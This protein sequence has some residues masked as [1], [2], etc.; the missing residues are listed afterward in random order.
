VDQWRFADLP[1]AMSWLKGIVVE[2][3][4]DQEGFRAVRPTF[5]LVGY[6][7]PTSHNDMPVSLADHHV[8]GKADFMPT[9]RNAFV[10]H[11]FALDTPPILR[12][13]MA[14]GDESRD[15]TSRQA[16]LSLKS[17]GAYSVRG[18]ESGEA[19]A[20]LSWQFDYFADD[21]R[22]KEGKPVPGEKT[23]TPLCFS[24]SPGMLH[25]AHAKKVHIVHVVRKSVVAK[26]AAEKLAPPLPPAPRARKASRSAV[27]G[28]TDEN[29]PPPPPP[30]PPK[31]GASHRRSRS[32]AQPMAPL[33]LA[34]GPL[35]PSISYH[36]G[37]ERAPMRELG[38]PRNA[39]RHIVPKD[40]LAKLL[41]AAPTPAHGLSSSVRPPL[42]RSS[43]AFEL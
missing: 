10:F 3:L 11:H 21:K 4:I 27:R 5:K 29:A 35:S 16:S 20:P 24:C 19:D 33:A 31:H 43:Q 37:L 41:D 18:A 42:R 9:K 36:G 32:H 8:Y 28:L 17:K 6:T 15:Y 39:T 7:G 26:L 40:V 38:P 22:N 1:V 23:L 14:N 13:V 2:L 30:P 25:P 34:S 12:R